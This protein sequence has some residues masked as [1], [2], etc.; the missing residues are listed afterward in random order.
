MV[1]KAKIDPETWAYFQFVSQLNGVRTDEIM[2]K[3]NISHA[4]LY[5][6]LKKDK[7]KVNKTEA[8]EK[9]NT[10]GR[11]RKLSARDERLL[12]RNI[13]ILRK[14][15]G[16]FT[17]KRLMY[18]AGINPKTV[19][20][21]TVQRFLRTKGFQYLQARKKG[22]LTEADQLRR[23]QFARK[24][25]K[26]YDNSLWTEKISFYLDGVSFVHKYNP[27]D[28]AR[29][30]KGRIW[31]KPREG[32][33]RGCTAKGS[34]CG[35]GGRVAK[36]MVAISYREGVI[37]CENY[38]Q[39]NGA[40]FKNLIEREFVQM[41]NKA[42][43]GGSKT[44]VQDGDPSQNSALARSAW[45]KIRA[46]LL[47]IPPRSPDVNPIENCFNIIKRILEEDA[48]KKNITYETFEEFL[49]RVAVTIKSLDKNIID[50][51]IESMN[52]RMD[53]IISLNGGRM[54]Y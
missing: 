15:E 39:L 48:I 41:F 54:K 20:C 40:Y 46:K 45:F 12:L 30:P 10:M 25:K 19:S 7:T 16:H 17:V 4:S 27:A 1:F 6:I 26:D 8:K 13:P 34:H 52:K 21:R 22:V 23:L 33:A 53:L 36:F 28:Q 37:L 31:R 18:A 29:A 14:E 5:R 51:T 44:W 42:N 35:S 9:K 50:K 47:A 32:L 43:K 38:E 49:R 24:I 3:C 11:P 2:K